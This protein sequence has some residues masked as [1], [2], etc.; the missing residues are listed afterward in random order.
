MKEQNTGVGAPLR[1]AWWDHPEDFVR[2]HIQRWIESLM[3]EE[4]TRRL[5]RKKSECRAAVDALDGY[6]NGYGKPR[7]L[8]LTCGTITV[9]HPRVR[10]LTDR[11]VSRLL[12]LFQRRNAPEVLPLVYARVPFVAGKKQASETIQQVV[13]A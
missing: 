8:T 4:V 3:E 10:G 7:K 12:P 9:R 13:A 1:C 5:G 6:R 11:F 2:G